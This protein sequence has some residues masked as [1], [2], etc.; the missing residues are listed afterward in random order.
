MA[1]KNER[2]FFL[3]LCSWWL[4]AVVVGK[5]VLK[6]RSFNSGRGLRYLHG[7]G[8]ECNDVT[9]RIQSAHRKTVVEDFRTFLITLHLRWMKVWY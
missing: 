9:E 3:I 5:G 7:H 1:A 4:I 8:W 6:V 2:A